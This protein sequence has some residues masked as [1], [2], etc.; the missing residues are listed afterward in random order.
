MKFL[1]G[2]HKVQQLLSLGISI[3]G[4][5]LVVHCPTVAKAAC[6]TSD[7]GNNCATFDPS[8]P[9]NPGYRKLPIRDLDPNTIYTYAGVGVD[10]S[11]PDPNFFLS[12]SDIYISFNSN[13][14]QELFF[15]SPVVFDSMF[16]TGTTNTVQLSN[17]GLPD[18]TVSNLA[19]FVISYTIPASDGL[20]A[21]IPAGTIIDTYL[22]ACPDGLPCVRGGGPSRQKAVNV[23]T[24]LPLLGIG[25]AFECSRKLRKHINANKPPKVGSAIG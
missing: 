3:F 13:Q 9:S 12:L 19:D 20:N 14:T 18:L 5:A 23:P 24:P 2:T 6:L 4:F 17:F 25:A 7:G 1:I 8:T 11:S 16:P 22:V 15:S 21:K 10:V